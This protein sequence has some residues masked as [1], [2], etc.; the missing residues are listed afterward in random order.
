MGKYR[1]LQSNDFGW[2]LAEI[3]L[4]KMKLIWKILNKHKVWNLEWNSTANIL[5]CI[6]K[7]YGLEDKQSR[8]LLK[9]LRIVVS[10]LFLCTYTC[11]N[12]CL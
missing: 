7:L 3:N 1:S 8:F 11:W 9:L 4:I 12:I 10:V 5:W 6:F 2:K